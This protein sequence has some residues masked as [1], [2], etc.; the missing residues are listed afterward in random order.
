MKWLMDKLG[1]TRE[2]IVMYI[3][4]VIAV[5]SIMLSLIWVHAVN[6]LNDIYLERGARLQMQIDNYKKLMAERDELIGNLKKE[7]A[8]DK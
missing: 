5:V 4:A 6:K 2:R 3:C 8:A 7:I 1:W